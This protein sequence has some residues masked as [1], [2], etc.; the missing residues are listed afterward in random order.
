MSNSGKVWDVRESYK[1][2][3]NNSWHEKGDKG[4]VLGGRTSAAT[5]INVIEE[6]QIS[7][8]GTSSDFGDLTEAKSNMSTNAAGNFV[9]AFAVGGTNPSSS[10]VIETVDYSSSGSG[11]DYGD[12]VTAAYAQASHSDNNR[13]VTPQGDG[14]NTVINYI[15][16]NSKGNQADFGDCTNSV[17]EKGATGDTTRLI[18]AGGTDNPTGQ[19]NVIQFLTMQSLGN[20]ADFGDL[21]YSC[22]S[23]SGTSNG[24]KACFAGG[25]TFSGG[26]SPANAAFNNIDIVTIQSAGNATDFGDLTSTVYG[27]A[28]ISGTSRALVAGGAD[29]PS[30]TP[31][32]TMDTF[33]IASAGNATDF[34]DLVTAKHSCAGASNAHGGLNPGEQLPSVTYMPGSGRV[35]NL[36]GWASPSY[37]TSIDMIV[38]ST[39]GNASDFGD[40][41]VAHG[42][43]GAGMS[44]L[45]RGLVGGGDPGSSPNL[46]NVIDSVEFAS[47]GNGADFGDLTESKN[48]TTG[49]SSTTRGL[50]MGGGNALGGDA[51]NVI[52]Y[53]TMASAGN[54]T[55]FGD[56]TVARNGGAASGS[57]TRGLCAGGRSFEPSSADTNIIDYVTISSTG[58]AT[59]FGDLT[60]ARSYFGGSSSSTRSVVGGGYGGSTQNVIDYVTIASTGNAT[61]FGDLLGVEYNIDGGS[62]ST[63]A[64]WFGGSPNATDIQYVEIATTSD[65]IDF[66]DLSTGK[67]NCVVV[68]DSHGGLQA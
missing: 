61:D 52:D 26:G 7:T 9:K 35:F 65:A 12:L 54:A 40:L 44:S 42:R 49:T 23:P 37:Y 53:V 38:A 60:V 11:T 34:A 45:T 4:L 59:D 55:D 67:T 19:V 14:R 64:I 24:V 47:Q 27:A 13:L 1:L 3:R 43:G 58:N 57:S 22:R 62:N 66:G 21:N 36:G 68:S 28:G 50:R 63:R 5:D 32:T 31:R 33:N 10:N 6:K 41:P 39:L 17:I 8:T 20:A 18:A 2:R 46:S 30:V 56:Q 16:M 51:T 15:S 25:L 48:Y 29:Y